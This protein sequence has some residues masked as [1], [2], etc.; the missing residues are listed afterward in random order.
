MALLE[1]PVASE[2]RSGG[3]PGSPLGVRAP[4]RTARRSTAVSFSDSPLGLPIGPE[5]GCCPGVMT[6]AQTH[7]ELAE[8]DPPGRPG[9]WCP[10]SDPRLCSTRPDAL[11]PW[12]PP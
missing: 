2:P 7:S 6:R 8:A 4:R 11:L 9:A 10:S 3:S 1:D 5:T 12:E